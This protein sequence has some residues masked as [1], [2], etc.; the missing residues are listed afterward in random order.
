M[1]EKKN[2]FN[3]VEKSNVEKSILIGVFDTDK[4]D[5]VIRN[6]LDEMKLLTQS[7]GGEV[8]ETF[9]QKRWPPDGRYLMGKGKID[10]IKNYACAHDVDLII[11]YNSLTNIQQ[12]NLEDFFDMKVIDRTRLILD[13]FATRARSLEGKL[14]VELAQMLYLLPRLTGRG[15]EMSRL[16]GGIGTRGPGETKLEADRRTIKKR[17]SVIRNKLEKVI[18]SREIQRKNRKNNPIPVVSL[19]GYTSAGKSTLFKALTGEDV[20]ISRMLFSTLDPLMRRVEMNEIREGYA[21]LLTDTVGFIREMPQE[22][23]TAFKATLEEMMQADLILHIID[24]SDPDYISRKEDVEGVLKEMNIPEERVIEVFNKIDR[25]PD[26][27]EMEA[28]SDK[29]VY[30][31][32]LQEQGF[33]QLKQAIFA[34]YFKDYDAYSLEL[35]PNAMN[36]ESIKRWAIVVNKF[37]RDGKLH[38]DILCSR[39]N[40]VKFKEK[41]GGYVK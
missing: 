14:Q 17:I 41:Y 34:N 40:M 21:F 38:A 39:E 22:L 9:F 8:V 19:I 5:Y 25:L 24:I 3:N 1:E 18:E 15:I 37:F 12:R 32:A 30:I 7:A 4:P 10:E 16:G 36:L 26:S 27:E 31:S 11:F 33:R 6:I 13:V 28:E 35:P 29:Q 23:F 20:P 2:Q